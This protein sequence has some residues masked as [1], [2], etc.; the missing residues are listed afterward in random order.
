MRGW[1]GI[2]NNC[3]LVKTPFCPYFSCICDF[4]LFSFSALSFLCVHLWTLLF[5]LT[6]FPRLVI[7]SSHH[8]MIFPIFDILFQVQSS[9]ASYI[10]VSGTTL[11]SNDHWNSGHVSPAFTY[12]GRHRWKSLLPRRWLEL[13]RMLGAERIPCF[14]YWVFEEGVSRNI[15]FSRVWCLFLLIE[16]RMLYFLMSAFE[17][18]SPDPTSDLMIKARNT[19]SR[20][21][22]ATFVLRDIWAS[23]GQG[24]CQR[25][26]H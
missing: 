19:R 25:W 1:R 4:V 11:A 7:I 18:L 22:L 20:L 8:L 12:W 23:I 3:F 2:S 16:S 6:W 26:G 10:Q 9:C 17:K 21:K 24:I 5:S 13:P 14:P 15:F